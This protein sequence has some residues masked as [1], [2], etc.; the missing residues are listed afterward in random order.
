[1]IQS[2]GHYKAVNSIGVYRTGS[3]NMS[4]ELS[5]SESAN[6]EWKQLENGL[7]GNVVLLAVE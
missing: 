7:T 6:Q 4:V 3:G 1:M 2:Q 5:P